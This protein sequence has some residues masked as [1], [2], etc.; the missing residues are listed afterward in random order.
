FDIWMLLQCG[1]LVEGAVTVL[2]WGVK[3]CQLARHT[4]DIWID[5]TR[6]PVTWDEPMPGVY[7]P[8]F[9][10]PIPT[11]ARRC[12]HVY[13]QVLA[14]MAKQGA[15]RLSE[16]VMA[17][18]RK[19][20]AKG[21]PRRSLSRRPRHL[22]LQPQGATAEDTRILGHRRRQPFPGGRRAGRRARPAW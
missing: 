21:W 12:R 2:A 6:I 16:R 4:P 9:Q 3:G 19:A 8:W 7:R 13:Y 1:A 10:C 14:T 18:M 17:G 15:K 5:G 22:G 20:A 11:C